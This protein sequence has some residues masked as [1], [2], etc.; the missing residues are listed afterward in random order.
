MPSTPAR[1]AGPESD[2]SSLLDA[3]R[4]GDQAALERLIPLVYDELHSL[5]RRHRRGERADHTLQTTDLVHEAYLRL[6]GANVAWAGRVHF[7]A[8]AA[9]T[10]RRI[11]VDHARGRATRKRGLGW[12]EMSLD[13]ADPV[14]SEPATDIMVIDAALERLAALDARKARAA[15]LHYF[16]GLSYEET[17]EALEVSAATIHRDL[18][19]ARA[20]LSRALDQSPGDRATAT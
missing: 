11:L 14:A 9:R 19:V 7:L 13:S 6:V 1:P 16:G 10:M 2:I 12:H 20:Y 15:E 4:G 5:A 8:V 3:W 18:R 17:A